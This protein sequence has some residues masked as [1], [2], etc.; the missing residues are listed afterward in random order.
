[1]HRFQMFFVVFLIYLP[2]TYFLHSDFQFDGESI[3]H[4]LSVSVKVMWNAHNKVRRRL[5]LKE[6]L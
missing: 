3:F 4:F 1:M 6:K 5:K 2:P